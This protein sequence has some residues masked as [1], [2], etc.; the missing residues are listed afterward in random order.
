VNFL[1]VT[2]SV[3]APTDDLT[4]EET[5]GAHFGIAEKLTKMA[6]D[7]AEKEKSGQVYAIRIDCADSKSVKEAFE[8][9]NS[10]GPVEALVYNTN[11]SFPW[12]PPKFTE[13][14]VESFQR[15]ITIPC[16]GAFLC[17]QQVIQG[18]VER[19]KG[20]LLFTGATASMRGGAGFSEI[21]CGKFALRALA[22]SLAREYQPQG[23]HV[24]HIIV[25]GIISSTRYNTIREE[26]AMMKPDEIAEIYWHVH[27]QHKSAWTHELDVRPFPEKF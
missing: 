19:Q 6:E 22:Q 17:V 10:L 2:S 16:V 7:I 20:T 13:I 9:V 4:L 23:I 21:A 11:T 27:S 26:D 5:R 1:T 12:P 3:P 8:A 15:S 14:N 25:D 18:M 24:A